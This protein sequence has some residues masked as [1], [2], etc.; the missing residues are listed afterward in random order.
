[1]VFLLF[2]W[3]LFFVAP[4]WLQKT[5]VQLVKEKSKMH[6]STHAVSGIPVGQPADGQVHGLAQT[7]PQPCCSRSFCFLQ[8]LIKSK[9]RSTQQAKPRA[10]AYSRGLAGQP[11]MPRLP[12]L[13]S[14]PFGALRTLLYNLPWSSGHRPCVWSPLT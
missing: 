3:M 7:S 9:S 4:R 12:L 10:P 5:I 14:L 6:E 2:S 1:M 8:G 11:S 13:S